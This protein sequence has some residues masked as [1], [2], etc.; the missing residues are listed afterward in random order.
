MSPTTYY[1]RFRK[2]H[3][4]Y[5]MAGLML[6]SFVG[7]MP[8]CKITGREG[9]ANGTQSLYASE[10]LAAH[11]GGIERSGFRI[12]ETFGVKGQYRS[13]N[14]IFTKAQPF[15]L[16]APQNGELALTSLTV[17][18]LS[19][20][21]DPYYCAMRWDY[22]QRPE[23][24]MKFFANRKLIL[25]APGKVMR[26]VVV[27]VVEWGPPIT[28]DGGI[29]LSQAALSALGITSGST[30]GVAFEASDSEKTGP[31]VLGVQ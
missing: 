30:V 17:E 27:R 6:G 12:P 20:T 13:L 4:R 10:V 23:L 14:W 24:G 1:R 21:Q 18:D 19:R 15:P 28:T 7:F 11:N 2:L 16:Y 3:H 22:G 29:A 5:W 8:A 25:I 26:A 31:V 9:V